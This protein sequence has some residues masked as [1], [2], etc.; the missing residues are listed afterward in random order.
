MDGRRLDG[1]TI[2]LPCEPNGSGELISVV[3]VTCQKKLGRVGGEIF[4]FKNFFILKNVYQFSQV[5][6]FSTVTCIYLLF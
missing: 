4:F 6:I 5:T 3:R 2:S 1:Y